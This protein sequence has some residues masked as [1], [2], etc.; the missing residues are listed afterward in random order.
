MQYWL[1]PNPTGAWHSGDRSPADL[2]RKAATGT[3]R[4]GTRLILQ[5]TPLVCRCCDLVARASPNSCVETLSWHV[6]VLG[7]VTSGRW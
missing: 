1:F 5:S 6:M 2:G 3:K 4:S 7:G